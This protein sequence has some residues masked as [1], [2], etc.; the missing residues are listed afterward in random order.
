MKKQFIFI[1][2][3]ALL[4]VFANIR[5]V[6]AQTADDPYV[7]LVEYTFDE[8]DIDTVIELLSE[9]QSQTLEKE[10]GCVVYDLLVSEE[11]PNTIFI[12]ESY[13]NEAAFKVH[14]NS[15]YFKAIVPTKIKPL[16]K[17]ERITKVYPLNQEEELVDEEV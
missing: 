10:E 6:A 3:I 13:E 14:T 15:D 2:L 11:D 1:S 5:P 9:M 7:I 17:K 12:Y 16:I 8:K 4:S